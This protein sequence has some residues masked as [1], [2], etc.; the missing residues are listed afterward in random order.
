MEKIRSV[1]GNFIFCDDDHIP[2]S[3]KETIQQK[4]DWKA[5]DAFLKRFCLWATEVIDFKST[6]T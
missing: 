4:L 1:N 3:E 6:A 5:N 2:C